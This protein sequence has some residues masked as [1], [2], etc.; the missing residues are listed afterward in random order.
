MTDQL[1]PCPFCG[2]NAEW[3]SNDFYK[4]NSMARCVSCGA[5][6]F[7]K[8]WNDR[9]TPTP[10]ADAAAIAERTD[11]PLSLIPHLVARDEKAVSA[12]LLEMGDAMGVWQTEAAKYREITSHDQSAFCDGYEAGMAAILSARAELATTKAT[13]PV[14]TPISISTDEIAKIASKYNLGNPRLDALRGFVNEVILANG[15]AYAKS[16]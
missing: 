16:E 12:A 6:A 10:I 15:V 14:R 5:S 3:S 2:S 8:K 1:K 4:D 7:W 13:D 11:A 9:V